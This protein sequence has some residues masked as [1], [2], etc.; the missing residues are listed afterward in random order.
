M[1]RIKS[2][3]NVKDIKVPDKYAVIGQHM[4]NALIR[5]RR[6]AA[7]QTNDGGISLGDEEIAAAALPQTGKGNPPPAVTLFSCCPPVSMFKTPYF[8]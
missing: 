2:R 5:S 4:R 1:S 7:E 6:E 3:E 8:R